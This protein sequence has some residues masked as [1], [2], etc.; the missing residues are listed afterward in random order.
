MKFL[1]TE[2]VVRVKNLT[3]WVELLFIYFWAKGDVVKL[4]PSHFARLNENLLKGSWLILDYFY[5]WDDLAYTEG[6]RSKT[7]THM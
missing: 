2:D 4:E 7:T 6:K 1:L 5:Y 3:G